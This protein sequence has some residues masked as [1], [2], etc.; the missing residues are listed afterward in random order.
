MNAQELAQR[1]FDKVAA[2]ASEQQH[3]DS[4]AIEKAGD[5]TA[6]IPHIKRAMAEVVLPFIE[7]LKRH[8]GEEQFY[9]AT[10]VDRD[11]APVGVSFKIGD[12]APISIATAFG[13]IVVTKLGASGSSK[14]VA[15]VYPGDAEP[16]IANSGDLTREKMAK[17]VE[18]VIDNASG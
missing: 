7:E 13:N 4:V 8:F 14:G 10:Q 2:A 18:M 15:F 6:D 16:Y 3:Q 17:L 12:G 9:Y 11:H 5:R 1:F